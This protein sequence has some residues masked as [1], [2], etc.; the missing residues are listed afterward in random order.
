MRFGDGRTAPTPGRAADAWPT[1]RGLIVQPD[2]SSERLNAI[3]DSRRLVEVLFELRDVGEDLVDVRNR[4]E[5][6]SY[7]GLVVAPQIVAH[8]VVRVSAKLLG[9]AEAKSRSGRLKKI[10]A[11]RH[12]KVTCCSA[13][14]FWRPAGETHRNNWR[15]TRC[16]PPFSSPRRSNHPSGGWESLYGPSAVRG[17]R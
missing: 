5:D 17:K 11:C 15:E 3:L 12:F 16:P 4:S 7:H 9:A 6:H 13:A 8:V 14:L 1:L 10:F 2:R